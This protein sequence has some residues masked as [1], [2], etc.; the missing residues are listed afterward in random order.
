MKV[1]TKTAITTVDQQGLQ[2]TQ[3]VR[4]P[5]LF[6]H[7]LPTASLR[8]F[9]AL[10]AAIRLHRHGAEIFEHL[11]SG[12]LLRIFLGGTLGPAHEL[13]F[14]AMLQRLQSCLDGKSLAMFRAALFHQH[15]RGLR[16]SDRL[17]FFLQRRLVIRDWQAAAI[18]RNP[19]QLR[20]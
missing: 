11:A 20:R 17:Q 8:A 3:R 18:R 9:V 10:G 13:S 1:M 15:V 5:V 19:F 12:I 6:H 7:C 16:S 4:L 14:A 2:R